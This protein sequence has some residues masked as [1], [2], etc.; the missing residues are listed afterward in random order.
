MTNSASTRGVDDLLA[1]LALELSAL[2]SMADEI[3][4][5]VG[6]LLGREEAVLDARGIQNLQLLDILNQSLRALSTCCANAARLA[7]PAWTIDG[8]AIIGG[9]ELA[10]IAQR[11]AGHGTHTSPAGEDGCEM[12]TER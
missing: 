8:T 7:A 5:S 9:I 2:Q 3:E 4:T 10:C 6:Q 12:F 1:Q 11:L